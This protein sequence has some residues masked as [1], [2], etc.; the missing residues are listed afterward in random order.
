M[1]TNIDERAHFAVIAAD[2]DYAFAQIVDRPPLPWNG[3]LALMADHLWGGA[4]EGALLRLEKF[5]IIVEPAG[6]A[7][8]VKRIWIGLD[9]LE[10]RRHIRLLPF[11]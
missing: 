9:G 11:R 1:A 3:N 6:Q 8:V 5:R 2:D 4:E 7:D 10:L